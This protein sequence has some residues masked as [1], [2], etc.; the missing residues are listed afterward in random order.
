MRSRR[1][2]LAAAGLAALLVG[3]A[4]VVPVRA[5]APEGSVPARLARFVPVTAVISGIAA[6]ARR[7]GLSA[8]DRGL[9]RLLGLSPRTV[10][11]TI[12]LAGWAA[13]YTW[14]FRSVGRDDDRSA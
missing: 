2:A 12:F 6:L 11:L 5:E 14:F 7:S 4:L 3:G 13:F 10:E 1:A 9:P 8:P